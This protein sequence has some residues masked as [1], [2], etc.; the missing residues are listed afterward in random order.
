MTSGPAVMILTSGIR[1]TS[2]LHRERKFEVLLSRIIHTSVIGLDRG[3]NPTAI[4]RLMVNIH[5]EYR[6]RN[7]EPMNCQICQVNGKYLFCNHR[8]DEQT[9]AKEADKTHNKEN[10]K[11]CPTV[12]GREDR[13]KWCAYSTTSF[14]T[15]HI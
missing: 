1:R 6:W 2:Q 9:I 10:P 11:C 12:S 5:P 14:Q 15:R 7:Q 3:P 8:S 4:L 13:L